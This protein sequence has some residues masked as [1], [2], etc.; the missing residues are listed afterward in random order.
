M[1]RYT[2]IIKEMSVIRKQVKFFIIFVLIISYLFPSG[3][4]RANKLTSEVLILFKDK[5]DIDLIKSYNG[6]IK[7]KYDI[8][9]AVKAIIPNI[10]ISKL[11]NLSEIELVEKDQ[12]VQIE[13]QIKDWGIE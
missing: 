10:N 7:V 2:K 4:V 12:K 6:E 8:L 5:I 11:S 1:G 13:G 3:N 9:P